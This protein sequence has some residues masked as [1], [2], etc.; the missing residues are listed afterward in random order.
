MKFVAGRPVAIINQK[1]AKALSVY[2]GERIRLKDKKEIIA[3]VDIAKGLMK[4]N[5]IALSEEILEEMGIFEGYAVEVS[6][7]PRPQSAQY[8]LE[9]L[10]GNELSYKKIHSIMKDIVNNALTEAEI[11]YFISG[12][13]V[14]GMNDRETVDLTKAMV[15]T[16]KRME[17]R[18]AVDKHS[19]GGV[20]GNRTTPIVV[21]ICSSLGLIMPK[22][23]SKAITSAAG[24]ADV[25][26][27][28]TKVEFSIPE[29]KKILQKANACLVWGGSLNLAPADD[30]IIQVERILGLDP[31]V[32]LLASIL[33]KKIA[34]GAKQVLIDIPY[35]KTAKV[36]EKKAREIASKFGKFGKLLGLRIK[37]MLTDG[38]QPIGN[39]I[40]PILEAKDVY[41]VLAQKEGRP[42]DLENKALL[43]SS[44][45]L[46]MTGKAK[47]GQGYRIASD[48]LKSKK[49]LAQFRRI[50]E[51]QEGSLNNIESKLKPARLS[52]TVKSEKP[53]TVREISNKKIASVAFSAGC[54][55]DKAAG[56]YLHVHS[57]FKVQKGDALLTIY[58]ETRE[59]LHFAKKA[60]EYLR[61]ILIV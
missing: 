32:Q 39:G 47:K 31:E 33:S 43:V 2:V 19:I 58:A 40:G 50:I 61:P 17:I 49:A 55:A 48:I 21:S 10:E 36:D 45:I 41:S 34:V 22:T 6:I 26:E 59:K 46:E 11:A 30:K 25:M 18:N 4:E 29:I 8:I 52:F 20:A 14:H 16:G 35:G 24:T 60:Y 27:C 3:I 54:P 37:T 51:S 42:K 56:L 57:G 23:S 7:A 5:E 9:K 15:E 28:F 53:G 44:Q 38:S 13:Y 12:I 1:A